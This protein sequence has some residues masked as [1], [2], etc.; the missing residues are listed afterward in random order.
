MNNERLYRK[1]LSGFCA[2]EPAVASA[3]L[4]RLAADDREGLR[5]QVH[6]LKGEAAQLGAVDVESIA[7][8]LESELHDPTVG[9]ELISARVDTLIATLHA[10]CRALVPAL[11]AG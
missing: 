11:G 8:V 9:L 10:L 7:A 1:L 3:L 6:S 2:R 4:A 5:Q